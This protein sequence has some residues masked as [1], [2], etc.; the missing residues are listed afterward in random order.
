M[1]KILSQAGITLADTY[2]VE[3][4]IAGIDQLESRELH[5]MHEM[6]G[7]VFS[8]RFRTTIRREES[9]NTLQNTDIDLVTTTLPVTIT[10]LLGIQVVTD[11][12]VRIANCVVSLRDPRDAGGSEIPIWVYDGATFDTIRVMEDGTIVTREILAP[13]PGSVALPVFCGGSDTPS[14]DV[15]SE[16]ALRGR[17]TGFGA[18]TA[19]L[20][21]LYFVAFTFTPSVSSRGLPIPSW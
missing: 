13:V 15:V 16:L 10:R 21:V 5:I 18:G 3:G 17:T 2:N 1:T 20:R 14:P 19:I 9:G 6:G 8:E 12:G 7:T 11:N 4:S